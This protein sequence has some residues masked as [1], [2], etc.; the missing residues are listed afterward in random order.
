MDRPIRLLV[1]DDHPVVRDGLRGQLDSEDDLEVVAEAASAEEALAVLRD[2]TVDVVITDLRMPGRGGVE[3]IRAIRAEH[4][5]TEVLVLTTYDTDDD[6]RPALAA[7]A[8]SYLLKDTARETLVAAI[9]ATRRH[10]A[11]LAP[12]VSRLA[13]TTAAPPPLLSERERE[14]LALV[15]AGR[16]NRQVGAELFIG[17]AT[18]KTHLQHIFAKLGAT[19]RAAAVAAGYRNGLL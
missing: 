10:S 11:V 14:V 18:V 5:D 6:V 3:L 4:P 17:E 1:V 8:R 12:S 19:D 13:T 9:R 2:H 15:A 7:G 16:T